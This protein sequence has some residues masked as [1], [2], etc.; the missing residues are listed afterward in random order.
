MRTPSL[1][2]QS[3]GTAI[4]LLVNHHGLLLSAALSNAL[5]QSDEVLAG[6]A[7]VG[8]TAGVLSPVEG[9]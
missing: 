9:C 3:P 2:H 8:F 5:T 1:A 4:T 6:G 7:E